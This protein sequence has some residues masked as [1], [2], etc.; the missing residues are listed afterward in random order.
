MPEE[1]KDEIVTRIRA[2]VEGLNEL[3]GG[4]NEGVNQQALEQVAKYTDGT[5]F[6]LDIDIL[7]TDQLSKY[8]LEFQI[9]AIQLVTYAING[10]AG[11][12]EDICNELIKKEGV[13]QAIIGLSDRQME[14]LTN[15][16]Q[17]RQ[18]LTELGDV[19][20]PN[21]TDK[22]KIVDATRGRPSNDNCMRA[23]A[24]IDHSQQDIS[25]GL[26][27]SLSTFIGT[28]AH[29]GDTF[30][31]IVE[32]VLEA[33]KAYR[34]DFSD[35]DTQ[36]QIASLLEMGV[37]LDEEFYGKPVSED[38]K[39]RITIKTHNPAPLNDALNDM[40]DAVLEGTR[41]FTQLEENWQK[42]KGN[43]LLG[44]ETNL[45]KIFEAKFEELSQALA[46]NAHKR[47]YDKLVGTGQSRGIV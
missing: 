14:K 47:E 35:E 34:I 24:P 30:G 39:K 26:A 43:I 46:V 25:S 42:F 33:E 32:E 2:R 7:D 41:N 29:G 9:P 37:Q 31:K 19:A 17:R 8:E 5:E 21:G 12:V 4:A 36:E 23:V 27:S 40:V 3:I 45:T 38:N 16:E 1:P 44:K 20:L 15:L 11:G 13:F 6:L 28:K 10:F 22:A 18:A